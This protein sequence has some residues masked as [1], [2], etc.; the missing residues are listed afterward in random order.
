MSYLLETLNC[1]WQEKLVPFMKRF[2]YE[3]GFEMQQGDTRKETCPIG[4]AADLIGDKWTLIILRDIA[5]L[6]RQTFSQLLK[7]NLEGIS[8]ATLAKRLKRLTDIELLTV[9]DDKKHSQKKVYCLTEAAIEF[10]PIIFDLAHWADRY[11]HPSPMHVQPIQAYLKKD[12][13]LISDFL[14]GLRKVHL[15]HKPLAE[16]DEIFLKLAS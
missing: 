3:M 1:L 10:I 4:L 11:H 12:K 14:N 2:Y 7:K 16:V 5:I 9:E 6:S 8:S 15:E 13:K